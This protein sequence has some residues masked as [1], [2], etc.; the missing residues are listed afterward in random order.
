MSRVLDTARLAPSD[1]LDAVDAAVRQARLPAI[2]RPEVD[3][4]E[5]SAQVDVWPT[6]D[7]TEF[8]RWS[9]N[10]YKI[11]RGRRQVSASDDHRIAITVISPGR[12]LWRHPGGEEVRDSDGWDMI[13]VD[14]ASSYE[15]VQAGEGTTY[16]FNVDFGD[17][18]VTRDQVRRA[19]GASGV[20]RP[21]AA[22]WSSRAARSARRPFRRCRWRAPADGPTRSSG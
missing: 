13:L 2:L 16:A 5:F 18:G 12:W 10:A 17:L 20:V 4:A 22:R 9:S 6:G 1:R 8:L 7:D 15:F 21:G 11:W 3:P 14:H 19:S